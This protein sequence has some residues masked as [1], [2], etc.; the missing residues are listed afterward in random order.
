MQPPRASI[1]REI[2]HGEMIARHLAQRQQNLDEHPVF[3]ET[4]CGL[5]TLSL[6]EVG[7]NLNATVYSCDFNEEKVR[8]LQQRAGDRID[9]VTFLI[10]DSLDSL[11]TICAQHAKLG[12]V[13]LDAAASAMHTFKELQLIE[14]FLKPGSSLLIDN[15]ALPNERWLLSPCRKGKI[16]VPYL[17]A[18]AYWEVQGHPTAGDSMISAVHHDTPDYAHTSCEWSGFVDT[19]KQDFEKYL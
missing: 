19:W 10:G 7:K 13:F 14:A 4:G 9:N 1:H 6:A 17:M 12:F 11:R 15:A 8:A 18:S 16:V 5:S 3:V 2:T